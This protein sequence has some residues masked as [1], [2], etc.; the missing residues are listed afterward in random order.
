MGIR[1]IVRVSVDG[2]IVREDS[3]CLLVTSGE[4]AARQHNSILKEAKEAGRIWTVECLTPWGELDWRISNDRS[5]N[6]SADEACCDLCFANSGPWFHHPCAPDRPAVSA[7]VP[8]GWTVC[9]GCHEVILTSPGD[10]L[11]QNLVDRGA[12]ALDRRS[13]TFEAEVVDIRRSVSSFTTNR[14]GGWRQTEAAG[15]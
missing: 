14:T 6:F 13:P 10:L 12:H 2:R 8:G 3:Y 5:L 7:G 11:E 15:T 1:V 4:E 9:A